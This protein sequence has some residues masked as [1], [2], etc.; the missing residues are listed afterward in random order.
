[1][2]TPQAAASDTDVA[3]DSRAPREAGE[4]D[5]PRALEVACARQNLLRLR[6]VTLAV[7]PIVI[8]HI[9]YFWATARPGLDAAG[10][11]WR[12]LLLGAQTAIFVALLLL[13]ALAVRAWR[14]PSAPLGWR[15]ALPAWFAALFVG[16]TAFV[17]GADQLVS[18]SLTPYVT[19]TLGV[20]LVL[21][22]RTRSVLAV[23]AFGLAVVEVGVAVWQRIPDARSSAQL[24]G[25]TATG[26]ALALSLTLTRSFERAERARRLI[27]KQAHEL[28]RLRG[29]LRVCAW[30]QRVVNERQEWEPIDA[31]VARTSGAQ[32]THAMCEDC[33]TKQ[34]P[35]EPGDA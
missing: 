13:A 17:A 10:L 22:L 15:A 23:Y 34:F 29:L 24:N 5:E 4:G 6:A 33:F 1:M 25:V 35:E 11:K 2:S 28:D 3:R 31:F 18:T 26:I 32:L 9:V 20:A 27:A 7:A 19:A 21:R 14:A 12:Q 30:C 8:L 16:G